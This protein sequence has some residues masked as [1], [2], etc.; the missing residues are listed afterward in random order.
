MHRLIPPLLLSYLFLSSPVV[1]QLAPDTPSAV[2]E[3]TNENGETLESETF[4]ELPPDATLDSLAGEEGQESEDQGQGETS[5]ERMRTE[6]EPEVS[7]PAS[8][9]PPE[10]FSP[11]VL[12]RMLRSLWGTEE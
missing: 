11:L 7:P 6:R 10:T 2:Q 8:E 1:A 4:P 9:E 12:W 3:D 5:W